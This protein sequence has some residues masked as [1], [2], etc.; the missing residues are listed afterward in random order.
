M[1][2]S[3]RDLKYI[4]KCMY[5]LAYDSRNPCKMKVFHINWE[6]LLNIKAT[7]FFPM[8]SFLLSVPVDRV[9]YS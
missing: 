7:K 4:L 3:N 2:S 5:S 1:E 6:I 9:V 8:Q